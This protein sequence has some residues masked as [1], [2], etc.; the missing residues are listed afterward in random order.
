MSWYWS[1][2]QFWYSTSATEAFGCST[3]RQQIPAATG[4]LLYVPSLLAAPAL[5]SGRSA[6]PADQQKYYKVAL[7]GV[8]L[9]QR[10]HWPYR[11]RGASELLQVAHARLVLREAI[12]LL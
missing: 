6:F 9:R 11:F 10:D 5:F 12:P 4:G 2:L 7:G 8:L 1:L 3:L